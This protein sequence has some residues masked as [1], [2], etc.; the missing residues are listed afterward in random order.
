MSIRFEAYNQE[1]KVVSLAFNESVKDDL[2]E[3][4]LDFTLIRET[5]IPT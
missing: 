1:D 4:G 5:P 2:M 3:S